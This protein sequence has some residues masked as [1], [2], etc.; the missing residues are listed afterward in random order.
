M[1]T[2][3]IKELKEKDIALSLKNG[4]ISYSGPEENITPD[5]IEKLK[6]N[7]RKLIKYLWSNTNTNFMPIEPEGDKIPLFL[8]HGDVGNY[9]ISEYL[10]K[11]Q[12][13]Y[14]FFHP[15]SEGEEIR[16]KNVN[17]MAKEY[18]DKILAFYSEGPYYLAGFSFGGILA[19]EMAVQLQK[20]G[21]S[22]PFLALI[23][24]FNPIVKETV[25]WQGNILKILRKNY[26]GPFRRKIEQKATRILYKSCFLMNKPI[27]IERRKLYIFDKYGELVNKYSPE[28]FDGNMLLFK[29]TENTSS[30]KYLGWEKFV[31]NIKMFDV[32]GKHT[33]IFW[34]RESVKKIATEIEK[35]I[36][37][38]S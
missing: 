18:L 21:K 7:K 29:T 12:P 14:G 3:F 9:S 38:I 28:R 22:V 15:G 31:N 32:Y 36:R 34:N 8:V 37:T 1:F 17:E 25:K 4:K 13:V 35:Y 16:F 10:G 23:D 30:F 19:Y 6:N 27:P 11:D 26:L 5:L 24:T 2:E 33:E 20:K